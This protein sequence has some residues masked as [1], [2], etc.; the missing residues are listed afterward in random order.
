VFTG[1]IETIGTVRDLRRRG[2]RSVTVG[3][4]PDTEN[5]A[6]EPGGSVA[7]DGVCLTV[8]SVRDTIIYFTAV[9]ETLDRSTIG[10]VQSGGRVNLERALALCDRLDGH[11]V[12]GHV[13]A[14]GT[15]E[16]DRRDGDST[17]RTIRAPQELA[18][19]LAEKGSVAVDGISLTIVAARPDTFSVSLIPFTF[20]KTTMALKRPGGR[21]NIECDVIARY[22]AQIVSGNAKL[23]LGKPED[24]PRDKSYGLSS[25]TPK[26]VSSD[27]SLFDKMER[28]GF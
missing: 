24:L 19:F 28:S 15:I 14:V 4:V 6:V 8:E 27:V 26:D 21:V 13:D 17:V 1:I 20:E 16:T 5:F 23:S 18:P 7:C 25:G 2:G 9:A 11:F 3:I 22:L 12:L 10:S